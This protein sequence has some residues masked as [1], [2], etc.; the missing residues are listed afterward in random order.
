L[1]PIDVG[2]GFGKLKNSMKQKLKGHQNFWEMDEML[3]GNVK[4][5]RLK[6]SLTNFG[7]IPPPVYE[8]FWIR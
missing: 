5:F 7:Q 3:G 1:P 4:I 2:Y 6:S 8:V